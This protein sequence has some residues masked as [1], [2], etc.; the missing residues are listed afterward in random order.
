MNLL[1]Q[2]ALLDDII[3]DPDNDIPRRIYV[4]WLF[5]NG[6][7]EEAE[8]LEHA[9]NY[10]DTFNLNVEPY[11]PILRLDGVRLIKVRRG[12]LERIE[13]ALQT[14]VKHGPY[15][16][17]H[18][19]ITQV[20][21][22]DKEPELSQDSLYEIKRYYWFSTQGW[23]AVG[24][25]KHRLPNHIHDWFLNNECGRKNNCWDSE[26][27]AWY[28]LIL[29]A[30]AEA[31]RIDNPVLQYPKEPKV[32]DIIKDKHGHEGILLQPPMNNDPSKAMIYL[33]KF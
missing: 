9:L 2:K 29:W 32:G 30:K 18:N 31:K 17:K 16:V 13:C 25:Q 3:N 21:L 27:K 1:E 24:S 22:T 12:F 19:P 20:R 5:D 6:K 11:G 26:E 4:D 15:L 23:T 33:D 7:R 28:A 8:E 10:P 14:W